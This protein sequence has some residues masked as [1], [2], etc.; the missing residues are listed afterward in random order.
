MKTLPPKS[1]GCRKGEGPKQG[2][3]SFHKSPGQRGSR[4]RARAI[5]RPRSTSHLRRFIFPS[6]FIPAVPSLTPH[7]RRFAQALRLSAAP[8][9]PPNLATPVT[10]RVKIL[11]DDV[12]EP[13]V[14]F[15]PA[16]APG[17]AP[18]SMFRGFFYVTLW[19][20]RAR[21]HL[22]F[23]CA[24]CVFVALTPFIIHSRGKK[25]RMFLR[26]FHKAEDPRII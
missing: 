23:W 24:K 11:K 16:T 15:T 22:S 7:P 20:I 19:K 5:V 17:G 6:R 4:S 8:Q 14:P 1:I 9:R 25:V 21:V 10:L 2:S 3:S 13:C 12:S 26:G 18:R